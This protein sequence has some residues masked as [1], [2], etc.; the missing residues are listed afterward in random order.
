MYFL[1]KLKLESKTFSNDF[2]IDVMPFFV[3]ITAIYTAIY[4]YLNLLKKNFHLKT[5]KNL[6]LIEDPAQRL[7]TDN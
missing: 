7:T 2:N 3:T 6:G 4:I 5:R 1:E